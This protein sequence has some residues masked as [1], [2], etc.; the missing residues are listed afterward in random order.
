[1]KFLKLL[2]TVVKNDHE[3]CGGVSQL[4]QQTISKICFKND[5]NVEQGI[6]ITQIIMINLMMN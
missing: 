5:V 1:M 2:L 4:F 3:T 6:I